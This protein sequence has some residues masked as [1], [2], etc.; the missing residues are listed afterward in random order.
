MTTDSQDVASFP[1][2]KLARIYRK[3]Q[4]RVQELTTAYESEVEQIKVQQDAIRMALKD[5]ML[6]LGISSVRTSEGTVVLGT[7]T[8]YSTQD[9]DAFK[10]FVKDHDALDLLEKRIAQTNMATFLE[11]NPG[12]V[13]PGLNTMTE[14]TVSVR[15]PTK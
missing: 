14:Y 13:P 8:R 4:A 3:M 7:K 9:W 10:Q 12:A 1:M 6:A 2:D 15:K 11:E 5:Q